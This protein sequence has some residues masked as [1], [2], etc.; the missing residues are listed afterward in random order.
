MIKSLLLSLLLLLYAVLNAQTLEQKVYIDFGPVASPGLNT[1][2]PTN[3]IY[4]NNN[5]AL[6]A[7][8]SKTLVNSANNLSGFS[9]VNV[10]VWLA[11]GG[12]GFGGL[13]APNAALLGDLAVANATQD[14]FFVQ[15]GTNGT[16]SSSIKISGLNTTKGYKFYL[17]GTRNSADP[18]RVTRYTLTGTSV[19]VGTL[20]TS[21]T[22]LGGTGYNGNNSSIYTTPLLYSDA[23]GEI[24]IEVGY[25]TGGYGYLGAMKIEE[26]S[27]PFVN[28][29]G[30]TVSGNNITTDGATSQIAAVVSPSNASVADVTWSVD[31]SSIATISATGLL[32]AKKNGTVTVTATTKEPNSTVSGSAQITISNQLIRFPVTFKIIDETKTITKGTGTNAGTN[33]ITSISAEL[34]AQNPRS[35]NPTDWWYPMYEDATYSPKGIFTDNTTN[36]TWQTTLTAAPGTYTWTPYLKSTG[37]TYLNNTYIYSTSPTITFTVNEDGSISGKTEVI[38]PNVKYRIKLKVIDKTKGIL[39]SSTVYP[40]NNVVAWISGGLNATTSWFYGFYN[41]DALYPNGE[42]IKG[43]DDW[44]WQASFDAPPGVYQWN[45]SMKSLGTSAAE[46]KTINGNVPNVSWVGSN[47]SFTVSPTGVLSGD[48]VLIMEEDPLNPVEKTYLTLNVNMNGIAVD[49]AGMHVVGTFNGWSNTSTSM[50]DIDADGIYTAKIEVTKSNAPYE[51]KFMN[52]TSWSNVEVVFGECEF[53]SN[54]LALVDVA[55]LEMAP[56]AFGY[57]GPTPA[58]I[59]RIKV[60]CVGSS[61]TQGAGTS[62]QIYKSWPIQIRSNLGNAFYTENLGVSGTTLQSIAGQAWKETNQYTYS[63]LLNPDIVLMAL[64]GN[65]TKLFNWDPEKFKADY[66]SLIAEFKALPTH[67]EVYMLMPGKIRPNSYA[68]NDSVMINWELPIVREISKTYMVPVIDY[69]TVTS[70]LAMAPFFP[71]GVH[72]NDDGAKLIADKIAEVILTPKPIISVE[73]G[74]SHTTTTYYELR[75]YFN[76]TLID[77]SNTETISATQSG[78]YNVAVKISQDENH[79]LISKPFELNVTNGETVNLTTKA[80]STG[81]NLNSTEISPIIFTDSSTKNLVVQNA[82]GSKLFVYGLDGILLNNCDLTTNK[83]FV[84]LSNLSQGIY[85]CK[86]QKNNLVVT[87]KIMVN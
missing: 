37:W 35:P 81:I 34:K 40:D 82:E 76:G 52:G 74:S 57:C 21:G 18:I 53:R 69:N 14:Y 48:T 33:V 31:D 24:K 9:L 39:S 27:A 54:R 32:S 64:G 46:P 77:N 67:P 68:L 51:Y 3:G 41:G 17:F 6:T 15:S 26:Y 16:N 60:A 10:N 29:A 61:T 19:T 73:T 44:T 13:V 38:I 12:S 80:V 66:L 45:P 63:K 42:L 20:Q 79:I 87:Q 7:N 5:T 47:L 70:P 72:G 78:V 8:A 56:V 84:N 4:W 85:L 62:S 2:N 65:D 86:V 55:S 36:Y 58:E 49:P 83:Q 71:D 22:N 30:I 50:T 75:W 25:T 23:N 11:N 28:V 43:N 59:T 1:A